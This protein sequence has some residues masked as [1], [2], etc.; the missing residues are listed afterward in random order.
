[1]PGGR[2]LGYGLVCLKKKNICG[3]SNDFKIIVVKLYKLSIL[4]YYYNKVK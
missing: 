1:M 2:N 3:V 4:E